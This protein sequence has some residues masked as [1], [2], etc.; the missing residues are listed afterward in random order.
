MSLK[1]YLDD[2]KTLTAAGRPKSRQAW[3]ELAL[4]NKLNVH[5]GDTIYYINTGTKKSESDVKKVTHYYIYNENN[6]KV[7]ITKDIDKKLK[8]YKKGLNDIEKKKFKKNVWMNETFPGYFFEEEIIMNCCLVPRNIIDAEYD[9]YCED[10]GIEYNVVKYIDMFN[11]RITPLLVCFSR[12]IRDQILITNP[13]DKKY[14]TEEQC[15]LS[16]GEPNKV[17]DQDTYE[18]LMTMEDKEYKFWINNNL[19]PPFFE[20]C[21]MGVW[22]EKKFN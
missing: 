14:F 3:Y 22:E 9:T 17:S 7:E 20:E 4:L 15:K 11:K 13:D 18:Q 6:E 12:E 16:S 5:N 19:V 21:G 1:E 10:G 2:K 8:E